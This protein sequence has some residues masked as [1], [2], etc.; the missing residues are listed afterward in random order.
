VAEAGAIPA[1]RDA[2]LGWVDDVWGEVDAWVE[3]ELR[4]SATPT[5]PLP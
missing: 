5:P 3:A 2:I 4:P 1:D